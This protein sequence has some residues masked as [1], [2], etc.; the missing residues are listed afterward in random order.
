MTVIS[1]DTLDTKKF[2]Y[3]C[4]KTEILREKYMTS[5][6]SATLSM[7]IFIKVLSDHSIS[8]SLV[9]NN[10]MCLKVSDFCFSPVI[11]MISS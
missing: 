7:T 2:A 10:N 1:S 8:R 9:T 4:M 11:G 3:V 5:P 6:K